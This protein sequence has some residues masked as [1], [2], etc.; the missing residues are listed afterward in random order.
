VPS[1]SRQQAQS[2]SVGR[3]G[4]D[5]RREARCQLTSAITSSTGAGIALEVGEHLSQPHANVS[6]RPASGTMPRGSAPRAR[7][8]RPQAWWLNCA[9]RSARGARPADHP[10]RLVDAAVAR[11]EHRAHA[12]ELTLV[13]AAPRQVSA[14]RVGEQRRCSIARKRPRCLV[15]ASGTGASHHGAT[16]GA[17]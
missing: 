12:A 9:A 1:P 11:R 5:E 17:S 3:L 7:R 13:D 4:L 14:I 15:V 6:S 16:P 8:A 10:D 2:A